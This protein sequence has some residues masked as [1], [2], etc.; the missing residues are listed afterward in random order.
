MRSR[1]RRELLTRLP[2]TDP[3]LRC[4]MNRA[5]GRPGNRE[6]PGG[7]RLFIEAFP[8]ALYMPTG[9]IMSCFQATPMT[10]PVSC[11]VATFQPRGERRRVAGGLCTSRCCLSTAS[12]TA[13][14][15][16][17]V[18]IRPPLGVPATR[19]VRRVAHHLAAAS[20]CGDLESRSSYASRRPIRQDRRRCRQDPASHPHG[21]RI[22]PQR[23][24]SLSV[25]QI[26]SSV[27]RYCPK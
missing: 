18:A 2:P 1:I 26:S 8:V 7:R 5:P 11:R 6:R 22:G 21:H 4:S 9:T 14:R 3:V 15:A 23:S 16:S 19:R 17:C 20:G 27:R 10:S 24:P 12:R 25:P 13:R